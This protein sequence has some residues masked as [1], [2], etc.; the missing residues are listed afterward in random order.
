MSIWSSAGSVVRAQGELGMLNQEQL[1]MTRQSNM[2]ASG[3]MK[4]KKGVVDQTDNLKVDGDQKHHATES[5]KHA[6]D[7]AAIAVVGAILKMGMAIGQAGAA[8]SKAVDAGASVAGQIALA[9]LK[10]LPSMLAVVGA[11][12]NYF[13]VSEE[14]NSLEKQTKMLEASYSE[15]AKMVKAMDTNPTG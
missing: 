13:S 8:A 11:M 14:V 6:K 7:A 1:R 3:R 12:L 2:L 4:E 10:C 5:A 15:E 9:V